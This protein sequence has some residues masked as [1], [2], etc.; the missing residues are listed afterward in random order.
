MISTHS[1]NRRVT[2]KGKSFYHIRFLFILWAVSFSLL[3]SYLLPPVATTESYTP[4]YQRTA[5]K[6]AR[7]EALREGAVVK[8]AFYSQEITAEKYVPTPTKTPTPT[9]KQ[10]EKYSKSRQI[11]EYTWT[12]DVADDDRAGTADEIFKALN[13]YRKKNGKG[14]L[15]WSGKLSEFA[16]SRADLFAGQGKTDS[17]AGFKDFLN[18]QDGFTKMGFMKIGENS[19]Y[20]YKVT[21]VNLIEQVYAGDRPHDDNQLSS[22]W[23]HVGIGVN[24]LATNLVFA[25]SQM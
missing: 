7:A 4:V 25:G 11:G 24:G 3:I 8:L 19:S 2:R 16:R 23:S 9:P 12:I 6:S 21:G 15:S 18:N 14:E 10:D 1:S 20:G 5:V 22:D 17:H 13:E